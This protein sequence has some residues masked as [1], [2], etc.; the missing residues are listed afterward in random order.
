MNTYL[1]KSSIY[2][3]VVTVIAVI[4]II[5]IVVTLIM[6]AN[7]YGLIGGMLLTFTLIGTM[8]YFYFHSLNR[9]I[10]KEKMLVLKKNFGKIEIPFSTIV[11]V[12][13]MRNSALTMTMGSLGVFGFIGNTMDNSIS[14]VKDK[15]HM[16]QIVTKDKKYILS[17]ERPEELIQEIKKSSNI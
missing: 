17:S 9:I 14:F 12:K 15:Q 2:V 5:L 13:R 4:L 1:S 11:D 3:K 7:F 8:S 16:L 10:V 6:T